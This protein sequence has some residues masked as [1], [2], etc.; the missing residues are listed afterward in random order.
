MEWDPLCPLHSTSSY[1]IPPEGE[2]DFVF[3]WFHL[4]YYY[5]IPPEGEWDFVFVW[6]HLPI[7]IIIFDVVV[8]VVVKI[9]SFFKISQ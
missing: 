4:R 2:W 3:V 8:V 5:P 1:P 9:P 7:I 6:F